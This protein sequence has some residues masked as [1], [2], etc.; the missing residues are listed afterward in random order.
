M[1]K[2]KEERGFFIAQMMVTVLTRSEG[3]CNQVLEMI[4]EA[5][6]CGE[7]EY[8]NTVVRT[9]EEITELNETAMR[10]KL[11]DLDVEAYLL[12]LEELDA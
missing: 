3:A 11:N 6:D 10:E 2:A 8:G 1:A 9:E 4:A 5:A 12:D 7:N